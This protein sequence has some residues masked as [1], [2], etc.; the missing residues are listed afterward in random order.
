MCGGYELEADPEAIARAFR[1]EP[2]QLEFPLELAALASGEH[3]PRQQGL[4]VITR[5][6]EQGDVRR[7]LSR[8]RFGLVPHFAKDPREGDKHFNAR[9][10][11]VH[12][13][14]LF[15]GAFERRR[16][17]VPVTAFYEWQ[18]SPERKG[19]LRYVYRPVQGGF[20]ALAGIWDA[21]RS[22]VGDKTSS[23]AIITTEANELVAEVHPR[24]PVILA[25]PEQQA[26]W[27]TRDTDLSVLQG[28]LLPAEEG[29]LQ[30]LPG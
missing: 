21:W 17:L 19:A 26:L 23:F 11:T 12:D 5:R 25:S 14:P 13:R 10:E 1:V 24:M 6:D 16:C 20:L 8:A 7:M 22:P 29:S 27:L 9:G 18:R 30:A 3:Y 28:L 15:R 4:I 2:G